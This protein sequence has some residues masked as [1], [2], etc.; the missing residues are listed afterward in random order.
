MIR[1]RLF[2]LGDLYCQE[3]LLFMGHF[4]C[5][6]IHKFSGNCCNSSVML[7]KSVYVIPYEMKNLSCCFKNI[8]QLLCCKN[9]LHISVLLTNVIMNFRFIIFIKNLFECHLLKFVNEHFLSPAVPRFW[10]LA[11]SS[12]IIVNVKS[13]IRAFLDIRKV[14]MWK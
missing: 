13:T 3:F 2:C 1:T 14:Y 12:T 11:L 8:E 4:R 10:Y 6:E 9:C 7:L 5:N